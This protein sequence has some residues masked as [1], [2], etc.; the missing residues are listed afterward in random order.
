MLPVLWPSSG[1]GDQNFVGVDKHA[2]LAKLNQCVYMS[3]YVVFVCCVCVCVCVCVRACVCVVYIVIVLWYTHFHACVYPL[4]LQEGEE[5]LA[6]EAKR[7][8]TDED[9]ASEGE[10]DAEVSAEA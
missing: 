3:V 7:A 4:F 6:R 5:F 1:C 2:Y 8:K 9:A 10:K